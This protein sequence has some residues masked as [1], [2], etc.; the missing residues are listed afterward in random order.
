MGLVAEKI[1]KGFSSLKQTANRLIAQRKVPPEISRRQ[2]EEEIPVSWRA[3]NMLW[4]YV[5]RYMLKGSGTGFVTPPYTAY[6]EK[7]WGAVP[8]EDLPKHACMHAFPS[9]NRL[10]Y[11]RH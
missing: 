5:N 10:F 9:K 8:I 7:L 3:D 11:K 4:G 2:I 1:R 6:W